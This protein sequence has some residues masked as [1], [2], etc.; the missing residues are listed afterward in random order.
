MLFTVLTRLT[1]CCFA[2][3]TTLSSALAADDVETFNAEY[4]A[5][6][7][8]MK[9]SQYEEALPHAQRAYEIGQQLF[10]GDHDSLSKLAYNLGN[11]MLESEDKPNAR[12]V[13]LEALAHFE[14]VFG[15]EAMELV[16]TLRGLGETTPGWPYADE[17]IGYYRRA[18]AIMR[19][20]GG[21]DSITYAAMLT[22]AAKDLV[23]YTRA[24]ETEQFLLDAFEVNVELLGGEH[25]TT[26]RSALSLGTYY[27]GR[28]DY[29]NA[30]RYLITA[31]NA[32]VGTFS[33]PL[34]EE[35]SINAMLSRICLETDRWRESRRYRREGRKIK[36]IR[37][38]GD[39]EFF[40]TPLPDYP[41]DALEAGV[42]GTVKLRFFADRDGL[43]DDIEVLEIDGPESF[44]EAAIKAT[45]QN[46]VWPGEENWQRNVRVEVE[47]TFI[48]KINERPG[49]IESPQAQVRAE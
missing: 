22:K 32:M 1:I 39:P 38:N 49:A 28:R 24:D 14:Q 16:P 15:E 11:V 4:M 26:G 3:A 13:F 44:A 47:R 2:L 7:E 40:F 36:P 18:Q 10:V 31:L 9:D 8:L 6:A 20:H 23:I 30:E 42:E 27:F 17:K 35:F 43:I 48:F 5:Y 34:W 19:E 45:K 46:V 29:E 12:V 21:A 41:A 37:A 33:R 25:F